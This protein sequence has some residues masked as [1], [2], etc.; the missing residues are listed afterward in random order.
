MK[1]KHFEAWQ[2]LRAKGWLRF[3]IVRGVVAWGAPMFL[4]I[5]LMFNGADKILVHAVIWTIGGLIFGASTWYL[6]EKKYRKELARRQ[7][8]NN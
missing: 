8:K 4:L 2:K 7:E 3:V 6:N 5:V 1:D